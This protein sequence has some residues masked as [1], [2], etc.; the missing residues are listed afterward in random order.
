MAAQISLKAYREDL[1]LKEAAL[2]L[3]YLMAEQF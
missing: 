3:G 1:S 2:E